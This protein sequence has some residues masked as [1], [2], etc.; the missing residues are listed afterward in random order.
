[1]LASL[2]KYGTRMHHNV[3]TVIYPSSIYGYG[4][5]QL[6]YVFG[7]F[8]CTRA[9]TTY[10]MRTPQ[11]VVVLQEF[12]VSGVS[13]TG[14]LRDVGR[15]GLPQVVPVDPREKWVWLEVA[16]PIPSQSGTRFTDQPE[17]EG[18]GK[19][20]GCVNLQVISIKLQTND[21]QKTREERA[22]GLKAHNTLPSRQ[23]TL[24]ID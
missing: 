12:K 10:G 16:D 14:V 6:Q 8:P 5:K 1:M 24:P 11:G 21:T 23:S 7:K 19:Q 9:H 15:F 2:P 17:G 20:R 18:R 3:H 13:R 4:I 22:A